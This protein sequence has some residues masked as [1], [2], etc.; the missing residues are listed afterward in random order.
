M[1]NF[2]HREI[3]A[4]LDSLKDFRRLYSFSINFESNTR[5]LI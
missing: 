2:L 1:L 4:L 5:I 3:T